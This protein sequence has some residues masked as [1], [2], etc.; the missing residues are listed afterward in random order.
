MK[1]VKWI[2][3]SL[4]ALIL[5]V[6]GALLVIPLFVDVEKYKPYIEQQVSQATG[7][8]FSIGGDLKV[9]LFPSA[10]V[11]F[12][13]LRLGN[14]P[15]FTEKDLLVVESFEA[16][17]RLMPLLSREV[18]VERF[19]TEGLKVV[20]EKDKEGK[21]NWE[22]M[23]KPA[24]T[25]PQKE[26]EAKGPEV[27]K[28]PLEKL[29]VKNF[30]AGEIKIKNADLLWIDGVVGDRKEVS[31]LALELRDVS[32]ETPVH[33]LFSA[34]FE[35]NPV[36]IEGTIGP[37]GTLLEGGTVPVDV[38]IDAF[39]ELVVK[40]KG[41][42]SD[43]LGKPVFDLVVD[44]PPFSPRKVVS[45]L[46]R[47]F[48]V[49]TADPEALAK[50]GLKT[51][52]K[53]DPTSVSLTDGT[54]ELDRSKIAFSARAKDFVDRP[55]V[56]LKMSIDSIDLD[57]YL[58]PT[59]SKEKA[60]GG[61][62]VGSS[63]SPAVEKKGK[64]KK[65][66][67][68]DYGPFRKATVDMEIGAGEIKVMG[69]RIQDVL[70]KINGRDGLFTV[71]P[72]EIKAYGGGIDGKASLNVQS[73]RP[74]AAV[75]MG[76]VDVKVRPLIND[77]L[78][79]DFLEGTMGANMA[80][81]MEGDDPDTIKKTL[82]GEGVLNVTDG[83]VIG[84]DLTGMVR[85]VKAAFGVEAQA[86]RPKTDFSE[87]RVP[88][89]VRSGVV[90]ISGAELASPL[91]RVTAAGSADLVTETLDMRIEPKVVA[92]LKGQ[93]DTK[94]R[95]GIMIPVLVTGSFSS[96]RFAPDLKGVVETQIKDVL[97]TPDRIKDMFE[98]E[99]GEEEESPQSEP[100]EAIKGIIKGIFGR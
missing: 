36:R 52:V 60:E 33:L 57:R 11:A 28:A 59:A 71:E 47:E 76:V 32:F 6:I 8:P 64:E 94:E 25:T 54:I 22:S 27:G 35:G 72:M 53:G 98:G 75:S 51:A 77:L 2:L 9:S 5:I 100:G 92:T 4:V 99:E 63:S 16:K 95:S 61:P 18:Q 80:V 97:K 50:V 34:Y 81:T 1:A 31:D 48:P 45:A 20:L 86:E 66:D 10:G 65:K 42:L 41:T 3:I 23:V 88:F 84:I 78:E 37:L 7:C 26:V 46:G 90:T 14:P 83:A 58:P 38:S 96:P 89:T 49:V 67:K 13:D 82:N 85:N 24:S 12:S 15:G 19:V 91:L 74:K 93:Q 44:V 17:V 43:V 30:V 55:D 69:V 87:L 56:A 70:I 40:A 29:P 62:A 68:I 79:K 21:G 73:D 39:K